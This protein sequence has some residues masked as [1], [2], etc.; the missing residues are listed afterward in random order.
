MHDHI[1]DYCNEN[2]FLYVNQSGFR[3]NHSSETGYQLICDQ[4]KKKVDKGNTVSVFIKFE[5]AFETIDRYKLVF[6]HM[7]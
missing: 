2:N 5:K 3:Q 1:T 4:Q 7:K 6:K